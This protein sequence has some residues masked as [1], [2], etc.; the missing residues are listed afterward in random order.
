MKYVVIINHVKFAFIK[1]LYL[2][3]HEYNIII[4]IA[5][6]FYIVILLP[7]KDSIWASM[8]PLYFSTFLFSFIILQCFSVYKVLT[9]L[10]PVM[11][12]Y[13]V[14]DYN[15]KPYILESVLGELPFSKKYWY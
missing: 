6:D 13:G 8:N 5:I 7:P 3:K 2:S 12:T 1:Q 4:I 9:F 11:L 10:L 14:I 15:V